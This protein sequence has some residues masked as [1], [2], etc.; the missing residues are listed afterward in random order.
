MVGFQTPTLIQDMAIPLACKGKNVLG[1]A[2]TGTGKTAC[3]LLPMLNKL[4]A[5]PYG[6]FG[7]IITPTRELAF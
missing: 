5:D 1:Y 7:L 4:A 2:R 3:F 6:I